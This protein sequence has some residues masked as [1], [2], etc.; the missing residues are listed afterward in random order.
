MR[1]ERRSRAYLIII[2]VVVVVVVVI[3][4]SALRGA[5]EKGEVWFRGE[6]RREGRTQ[7]SWK[8]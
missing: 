4:L 1:K 7:E 2:I 5:Q 3:N 8:P 6:E